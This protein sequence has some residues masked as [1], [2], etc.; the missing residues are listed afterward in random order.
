MDR[1]S[2]RRGSVY[3]AADS[4]KDNELGYW[5]AGRALFIGTPSGPLRIASA[6]SADGH[7]PNLRLLGIYQ[8]SQ[9]ANCTIFEGP[10]GTLYYKN[11]NGVTLTL[12]EPPEYEEEEE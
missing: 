5:T 12:A 10:E 1:I 6:N 3:P 11:R 4:L 2:I 8:A 9:V 7:F